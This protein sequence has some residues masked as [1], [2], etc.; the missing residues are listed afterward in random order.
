MAIDARDMRTAMGCFA[1]G[2]TVVTS[3]TPDGVAVGMTVNSFNS[4]SL[5]PPLVLFS[6]DKSA[7][8]LE[9]FLRSD[10]FAVNILRD[11]QQAYSDAF[12][13]SDGDPFEFHTPANPDAEEAPL[14]EGVLASFQG[15]RYAVHEGGDH[16]IFII[17]V[18]DLK[19]DASGH[20]LLYYRG[21]YGTV[22]PGGQSPSDG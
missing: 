19:N 5:E 15:R 13:V 6:I 18:T 8:R 12:A 3:R 21:R 10:K 16:Y 4:V 22:A 9:D 11:D 2:I 17:E 7:S 1:T 14:L 20:P